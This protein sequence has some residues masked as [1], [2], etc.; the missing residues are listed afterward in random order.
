MSQKEFERL[1]GEKHSRA[2]SEKSSDTHKKSPKKPSS[3]KRHVKPKVAAESSNRE[4]LKKRSD[5][6]EKKAR[7]SKPKS[8]KR[9]EKKARHSKSPGERTRKR[10]SVK[11]K[12]RVHE[13]RDPWAWRK[14]ET[15]TE[16]Q[17]WGDSEPPP[18]KIKTL[19]AEKYFEDSPRKKTKVSRLMKFMDKNKDFVQVGDD[20]EILIGKKPIPGSDF[21]EIMHFLQK[22]PDASRDKFIPSR[23]QRTGM[24]IG[25]RRFL[26]ALHEA[27][28]GETINE[29]MDDSYVTRF[30]TKLSEFTGTRL[31][32]VEEILKDMVDSRKRNV[33]E[34]RVKN[35]DHLAELEADEEKQ[36]EE[37]ARA[38]DMF[39]RIER[40]DREV[41]ER[42]AQE[43][44]ERERNKRKKQKRNKYNMLRRIRD[45]VEEEAL[46]SSDDEEDMAESRRDAKHRR[47]KELIRSLTTVGKKVDEKLHSKGVT[48]FDK[49]TKKRVPATSLATKTVE[50]Y[51]LSKKK[52]P[53]EYRELFNL[54]HLERLHELALR[55][56]EQKDI[57][58][59]KELIQLEEK[60]ERTPTIKEILK[61][62]P[63]DFD[64]DVRKILDLGE[65]EVAE[66]KTVE[67][68]GS[69]AEEEGT[70][71]VEY[72]VDDIPELEGET[73]AS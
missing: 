48:E 17:Q 40:E 53:E 45:D 62:A 35:T 41:R 68:E 37:Q 28:E 73:D 7:R 8:Q 3:P 26:D 56:A 38:R 4:K 64:E 51:K 16:I 70:G 54:D 34:M 32:G 24:P 29:N 52:Q 49:K 15:N 9:T 33:N 72:D 36:E 47:R 63:L 61:D 66:E 12:D 19:N 57:P 10:P 27:M 39:E 25:T 1:T 30:A 60:S 42:L 43:A 13:E 55:R 58:T 65:E 67:G 69:E 23:D 6:T 14:N 18:K 5:T 44:A 2:V 11:K 46:T 21:I 71:D 59:V 22:G 31:Q 20:F 50:K